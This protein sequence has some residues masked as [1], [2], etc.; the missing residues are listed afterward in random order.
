MPWLSVF[1]G[2]S[3]FYPTGHKTVELLLVDG[4]WLSG[5]FGL[6]K[7]LV[8]GDNQQTGKTGTPGFW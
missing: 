4:V 3:K 7:K 6:G 8:E 5:D 1:R 2:A